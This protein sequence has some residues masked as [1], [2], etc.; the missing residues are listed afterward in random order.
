MEVSPASHRAP[1]ILRACL[2]SLNARNPWP[3]ASVGK[4]RKQR[5]EKPILNKL[6]LAISPAMILESISARI[7]KQFFG[8]QKEILS[9]FKILKLFNKKT[10]SSFCLLFSNKNVH[11]ISQPNS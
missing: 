11:F 1:S 6:L 4:P 2:R 5:I 8:H 7:S 9:L 10:W 3:E